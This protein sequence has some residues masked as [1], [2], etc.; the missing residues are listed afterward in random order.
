MSQM[1]F[2]SS[3]SYPRLLTSVHNIDSK[4][5]KNAETGGHE[6]PKRGT[7]SAGEKT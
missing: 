1:H 7:K 4:V 5:A 6:R 3:S 2:V